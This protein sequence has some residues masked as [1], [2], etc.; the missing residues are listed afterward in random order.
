[1]KSTNIKC[2][3]SFRRMQMQ[4]YFIQFSYFGGKFQGLQKQFHRPNNVH[5]LDDG[6]LQE[7][8]RADEVTVQVTISPTN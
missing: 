1:M 8:Y 3:G 7:L 4:R 5:Q 6:E 2:L